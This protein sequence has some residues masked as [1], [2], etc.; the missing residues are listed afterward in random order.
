MAAQNLRLSNNPLFE[1]IKKH[2]FLKQF[3]QK[4]PYVFRGVLT[5]IAGE[6]ELAI[7]GNELAGLACEDMVESRI[8]F[9]HEK[10]GEWRCEQGVFT[11]DRFAHLPESNWTLLVQGVDQWFEEVQQLFQYFDFLPQWRLEDIMASYAPIGGGVG[12]HF[13]YYDVFLLQVSGSREWK[14]GQQCDDSSALQNNQHVKLLEEFITSDTQV[15]TPGDMLYVPAGT[16]HWGTATSDDCITFSVGFRS[17]SEKELVTHLL[18]NL[19]EQCAENRRYQDDINYAEDNED[20]NEG[21]MT[22][23]NIKKNNYTISHPARINNSVHHKVS[24]LLHVLTQENIHKAAQQAFGELVTE[25]RYF[26][27]EEETASPDEISAQ[28]ERAIKQSPTLE[29][30]IPVSTRL[31]FSTT[32]L[33]VNGES[34]VVSESFAQSVCDGLITVA[35]MS[36]AEKTVL[37]ALI[38][39]GDIAL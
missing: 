24:E 5:D 6:L 13:D 32:E 7:D 16:A 3:W 38:E 36:E 4:K 35:A 30:S 9:G 8:I 26:S 11:E 37:A 1:V 34:Y 14:L 31:A 29:L 20:R 17:P 23:E 18:E 33:F 22:G 27:S 28:F 19:I 21:R 25:P 15:L 12:P 10:T 2:T 39:Q